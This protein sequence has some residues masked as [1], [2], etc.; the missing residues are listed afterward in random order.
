LELVFSCEY[1]RNIFDDRRT[2]GSISQKVGMS[3]DGLK[4]VSSVFLGLS[5]FSI[6]GPVLGELVA[7][8]APA[9]PHK[10]A[11]YARELGI[12]YE[13]VAFNTSDKLILRGW[14]F[15]ADAE[16][17]PAI[18]YAPATSS[19]LRSGLSLVPPLHHAGYH[20]LLFSYRGHGFSDGDRLGFTYGALE[21]EDIDAAANF[22]K[23]MKGIQ[24]IGAIGHSVGAVSI[25]LSAA[26]NPNIQA[27]V[28]ASPFNNVEEI[29]ETNRPV[30]FPKPLLDLSMRIS[31]LRK[32]YTREEIRPED[33]IAQIAPRP[34]LFIHGSEDKRITNEQ[35]MRLYETALEP[36]KMWVVQ[37]ASHGEV[38]SPVLDYLITHIIEFFD[39]A[40]KAN[41]N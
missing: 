36:K 1:A 7:T 10:A 16:D 40:L 11:S 9:F 27:V 5:I 17:A 33:V 30:M 21:S 15:P 2:P 8:I 39:E 31:E 13:E 28:A 32:G 37:G 26:R 38:R 41:L 29:W 23:E 24:H 12:P 25:I 3:L 22:L 19:D 6:G 20:V 14:F 34:I 35:A 4:I 18:L